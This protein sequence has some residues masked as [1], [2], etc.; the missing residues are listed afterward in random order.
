[1]S[2]AFITVHY[3]M[4][5]GTVFVSSHVLSVLFKLKWVDPFLLELHTFMR[6]PKSGACIRWFSEVV[7]IG[8]CQHPLK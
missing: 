4:V 2:V 1:M 7:L 3:I 6:F 8:Y 5:E